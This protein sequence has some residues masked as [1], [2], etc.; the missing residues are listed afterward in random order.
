L[1]LTRREVALPESIADKSAA[2][3]VSVA[4][5]V[6]WILALCAPVIAACL[7]PALLADL[8][9]G[10]RWTCIGM[11]TGF[12]AMG[13]AASRNRLTVHAA[14][15][16]QRVVLRSKA[17]DLDRLAGVRVFRGPGLYTRPWQMMLTDT[18]GRRMILRLTDTQSR[19]G[20]GS[21]T[22]W[23]RSPVA[24]VSDSTAR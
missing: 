1:K 5:S 18:E 9:V 4:P 21:W 2:G 13:L 10:T 19:I 15:L 12:A 3:A 8:T 24:T 7:L 14:T 23:N 6:W 16:S 17:M 20:G 11:A 22:C